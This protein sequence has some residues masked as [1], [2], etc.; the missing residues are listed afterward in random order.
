MLPSPFF[1]LGFSE[2]L[3]LDSVRW[4]ACFHVHVNRS[5]CTHEPQHYQRPG[6]A[7]EQLHGLSE[8][9]EAALGEEYGQRGRACAVQAAQWPSMCSCDLARAEKA[10]DGWL[11]PSA[12]RWYQSKAQQSF[13]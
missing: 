2:D 4:T 6:P 11:W 9:L 12:E 1:C 13:I 10:I 8:A 3:L 5:A 7:L